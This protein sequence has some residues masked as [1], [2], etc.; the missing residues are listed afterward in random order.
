LQIYV[1]GDK[2]VRVDDR[3]ISFVQGEA[4]RALGR[5]KDR[6]TR[7]DFHLSDVNS[8]KFGLLDKRCLVE[9]RPAGHQPVAVTL[10]ASNV[11]AAINGSLSK[12][13]TALERCLAR[14]KRAKSHDE[15]AHSASE[16]SDTASGLKSGS[17][18]QDH[19]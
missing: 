17:A 12:L 3:V 10:V 18:D 7:V 19:D 1:N 15:E 6:L 13:Q 11:R 2:N 16:S 4:D 8:H 14:P 9:A 5:Y